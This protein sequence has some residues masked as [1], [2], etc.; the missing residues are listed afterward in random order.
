SLALSSIST[1]GVV[2]VSV[3]F[4]EAVL[5]WLALIGILSIL[6]GVFLIHYRNGPI[7]WRWEWPA[8]ISACV[9]V[10]YWTIIK[11]TQTILPEIQPS[12]ILVLVVIP[13]LL[14]FVIV[15]YR[16]LNLSKLATP[17]AIGWLAIGGVTG[18]LGNILSLTA[19]F[20]APNPGYPLAIASVSTPLVIFV[21]RFLFRSS[22]ERRL[23]LATIIIIVGVALVRFGS[24]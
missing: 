7:S 22:L 1:L 12:V 6:F 21:S 5:S 8:L 15:R 9:P 10:L 20:R 14:T 11:I 19:V 17:L 18:A 16:R 23:V 4:L 3:L 2:G 13:Q 24:L